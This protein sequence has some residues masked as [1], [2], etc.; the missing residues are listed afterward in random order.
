M[1]H[2]A[3]VS[4]A[5]LVTTRYRNGLLGP[6]LGGLALMMLVGRIRRIP[7]RWHPSTAC[8]HNLASIHRLYTP[9]CYRS[10]RPAP[11]VCALWAEHRFM[12]SCVVS[13]STPMS[14]PLTLTR[15]WPVAAADTTCW[16]SRRVQPRWSDH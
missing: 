14:R 11:T 1:S 4:L 15:K 6:P 10:R 8:T 2:L 13:E 9:R 7:H 16:S 5:H 12:T 3:S